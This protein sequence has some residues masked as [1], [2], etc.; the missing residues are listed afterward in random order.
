VKN[1]AILAENLNSIV[2]DEDGP[3]QCFLQKT[4]QASR[5][6]LQKAILRWAYVDDT[7][8][9]FWGGLPRKR[10]SDSLSEEDRQVIVS[11]WDTALTIS[12]IEKDILY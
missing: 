6:T 2:I 5:H 7:R 1:E 10:R 4:L 9:N 11:F 3:I 12:P 8:D